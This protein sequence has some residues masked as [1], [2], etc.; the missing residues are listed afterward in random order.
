MNSHQTTSGLAAIRP[1]LAGAAAVLTFAGMSLQS[2]VAQAQSAKPFYQGKTVNV[3]I[4]YRP[5]ASYDLYPRLLARHFSAAIPGK[6][7]TKYSTSSIVAC[8][9]C[10]QSR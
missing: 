1:V 8:T 7:N 9:R 6:K 5:G 4:G 3:I 10:G 2:P